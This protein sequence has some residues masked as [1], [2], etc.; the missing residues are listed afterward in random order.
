MAGSLDGFEG[1]SQGVGLDIKPYGLIGVNRDIE[2][3]E[4]T[5][6]TRDAGVDVF[7]RVTSNLV[8]STTINTDF[9]ETEVD[10]RQVNLTRFSRFFPEKRSFFLED[11]GVFDFGLTTRGGG[12]G[13]GGGPRPDLVPFFSRRIGLAEGEPVPILVGQKLT[14]KV[15]R[16]DVGA[17]MSSRV[18]EANLRVR[19]YS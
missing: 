5:T 4:Q 13:G 14:G 3:A 9:A 12:G 16:F 11:A 19:I 8:S 1:L 7:Y 15:G 10:A 17:S 18:S 6:I 2:A